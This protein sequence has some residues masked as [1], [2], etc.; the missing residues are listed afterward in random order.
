MIF[1]VTIRE[2]SDHGWVDRNVFGWKWWW[3]VRPEG[4]LVGSEHGFARTEGEARLKAASAA[5]KIAGR[6]PVTP[7]T[8]DYEMEV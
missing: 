8:H 1:K 5:N 6:S 3:V 2:C 7:I 4:W